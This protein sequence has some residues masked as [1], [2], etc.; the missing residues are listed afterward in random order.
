MYRNND[1]TKYI[2]LR[3]WIYAWITDGRKGTWCYLTVRPSVSLKMYN[4]SPVAWEMMS[5]S[6]TS[7]WRKQGT[8]RNTTLVLTSIMI[9]SFLHPFSKDVYSMSNSTSFSTIHQL[10]ILFVQLSIP[11]TAVMDNGLVLQVRKMDI[12]SW[13]IRWWTNMMYTI[14]A[15]ELTKFLTCMWNNSWL[16]KQGHYPWQQS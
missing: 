11:R 16:V 14:L 2:S 10:W 3:T 7:L 13:V 12:W 15:H 9:M 5:G 4:T 8:V 1:S 6:D